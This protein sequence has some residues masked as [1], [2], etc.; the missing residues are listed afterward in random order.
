MRAR[1]RLLLCPAE[2]RLPRAVA[3]AGL[4]D[5]TLRQDQRG[6]VAEGSARAT[7]LRREAARLRNE[8]GLLP[9]D[10]AALQDHAPAARDP[11]R[12]RASAYDRDEVGADRAR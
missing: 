7:G 4:R 12:V 10:R 5:K 3:G 2:P 9:A 11:G 8:H 1:L 6:A